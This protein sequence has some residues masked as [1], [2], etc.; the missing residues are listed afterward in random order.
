MFKDSVAASRRRRD[1]EEVERLVKEYNSSLAKIRERGIRGVN[2]ECWRH[3]VF[4]RIWAFVIVPA[5]ALVADMWLLNILLLPENQQ[6]YLW[7]AIFIPSAVWYLLVIVGPGSVSYEE[8]LPLSDRKALRYMNRCIDELATYQSWADYK[9]AELQPLID[10]FDILGDIIKNDIGGEYDLLEYWTK[11]GVK[12]Y[13]VVKFCG[14]QSLGSYSIS[15]GY[16]DG[17]DN[18][19]KLFAEVAIRWGNKHRPLIGEQREMLEKFSARL[20]KVQ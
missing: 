3:G 15:I 6:I 5:L 18:Y 9:R 14:Q 11:E 17:Y 10:K 7:L 1:K 4:F 13:V 2:R 19:W 16:H 20:Q 12:F 8:Y